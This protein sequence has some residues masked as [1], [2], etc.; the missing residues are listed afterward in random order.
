M[1]A[2]DA[3]GPMA[4]GAVDDAWVTGFQQTH[5]DMGTRMYYM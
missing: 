2:Q 3:H 1:E 4:V 5:E